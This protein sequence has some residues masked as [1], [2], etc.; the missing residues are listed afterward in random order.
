[1]L[2]KPRFNRPAAFFLLVLLTMF[3]ALAGCQSLQPGIS[4]PGLSQ[5]PEAIAYKAVLLA[6]DAYDLGM[7]TLRTLEQ[8]K[9]IT[10]AQYAS[11][12]DT[13]GWPAWK[14]I[15]AADVA[16]NAWVGSKSD[17]TYTQLQTAF[18]AMYE[19]QKLLSTEVTQIQ[20]GK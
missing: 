19:A 14:A 15:K 16:V 11:I 2:Q 7:T 20:G 3:L 6:F 8:Q 17:S 10:S 18:A 12:K 13:Y 9:V 1:M 5:S 4:A